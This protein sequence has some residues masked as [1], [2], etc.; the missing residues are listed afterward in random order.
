MGRG[1]VQCAAP[2]W[3]TSARSCARAFR[4][5]HTAAFGLRECEVRALVWKAGGAKP[6]SSVRGAA[7]GAR[8]DA[9]PAYLHRVHPDEPGELPFDGPVG[10]RVRGQPEAPPADAERAHHGQEA[11]QGAPLQ[12]AEH[13]A[14]HEDP[15]GAP[16]DLVGD[17]EAQGA[18]RAGPAAPHALHG[19]VRSGEPKIGQRAVEEEAHA[20]EAHDLAQVEGGPG[21][22]LGDHLA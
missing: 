13:G 18:R 12:L 6:R 14:A 7:Q 1:G 17:D 16:G 5:H 21:A 19:Q 22:H 10:D 8:Q 3:S 2:R 15:E 4:T 9:H 20:G 11:V